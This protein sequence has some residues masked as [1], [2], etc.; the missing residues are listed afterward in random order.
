MTTQLQLTNIFIKI[1]ITI[2]TENFHKRVNIWILSS[3]SLPVTLNIGKFKAKKQFCMF[4]LRL[5]L[6]C[7]LDI[8]SFEMLHRAA[9]YTVTDVSGKMI[10][11]IEGLPWACNCEIH[12]RG[13]I[14][15]E[16]TKMFFLIPY[17]KPFRTL[18]HYNLVTGTNKQSYS[19]LYC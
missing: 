11:P 9:W 6:R 4:Y 12:S 8:R 5:P 1:I 17:I 19:K 13:R 10:G 3:A 15:V 2:T 18:C 7:K 14:R 16:G